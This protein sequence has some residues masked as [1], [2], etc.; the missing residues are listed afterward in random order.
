MTTAR[1]EAVEDEELRRRALKV[2]PNGMYGHQSVRELPAGYPQFFA[3]ASGPFVTDVDG[4]R[5]IDLMCGYGPIILGHNHPAVEAAAERQ[6]K[7][8]DCLHAP[9]ARLVEAA[10]CLTETV[11]DADWALF[12]KNGTDATTGCL[13]IARAATA[14]A[15]VLVAKGCYHGAAPWCTPKTDGVLASDRAAMRY[16]E[17]NDLPSFEAAVADAGEDLAAVLLTPFKHIEG[18]DQELVEPGFALRVREICDQRAALLILDD[19]R[20]GFRLHLG[21]SWE[22]LGIPVDLSAW[23]KAI[24]NGYPISAMTG[25]DRYREAAGRVFLTGSFWTAS[26]PMAA[27]I[28][29]VDVLRAEDGVARITAAG[30]RLRAGIELQARAAGISIRYTGHPSMPYLTFGGDWEYEQMNV[31]ALACL[32]AGLYLVPRHNW[33]LSLAH[34]DAIVDEALSCTEQAMKQVASRFGSG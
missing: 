22:P 17:Y 8:A 6:R 11:A 29:T 25:V 12:A 28:A 20:C 15:I 27:M 24:G 31:F 4:R 5:Y 10:E 33:F 21:G 7:R 34:S 23:S 9:T 19:V 32:Q 16:F 13:T 26:V 2:I 3:S 1:A 30:E 18:L 14:R